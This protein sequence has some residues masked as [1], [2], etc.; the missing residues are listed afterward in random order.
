MKEMLRDSYYFGRLPH[1]PPPRN[2]YGPTL[3]REYGLRLP[4]SLVPTVLEQAAYCAP[5]NA[6]VGTSKLTHIDAWSALGIWVGSGVDDHCTFLTHGYVSFTV[7]V[8]VAQWAFPI[9]WAAFPWQEPREYPVPV[10]ENDL[11]PCCVERAKRAHAKRGVTVRCRQCRGEIVF[12]GEWWEKAPA[13]A[14]L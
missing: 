4:P 7:A 2:L 5:A 14:V 3:L 8:T 11:Q 12:A 10:N 1:Q 6:E 9:I 13:S